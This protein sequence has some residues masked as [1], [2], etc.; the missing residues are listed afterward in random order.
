MNIFTKSIAFAFAGVFFAGSVSAQTF[1]LDKDTVKAY[2]SG[3]EQIHNDI[4]NT[5][6]DS[7]KLTWQVVYHNVNATMVAG[8]G[9]CDNQNCYQNVIGMPGTL[10]TTKYIHA[11]E[12]GSFDAQ[13]DAMIVPAGGPYYITIEFKNG[14]ET[15]YGTYE[16]YKWP[17]GI[18]T[19][20]KTDDI[21]LYPNPAKNDLNIFSGSL[22]VKTAVIT[23]TIGQVAAS[24]QLTG[25]RS[26]INIESLPS[27]TY[28]IKLLDAQNNVKAIRKIV[29]E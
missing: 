18:A 4:S 2:V 3:S 10:K 23:T 20:N 19:A 14:T 7:I 17:T 27:G 6:T 21:M 13:F 16:F 28:F 1:H 22:D 11:G 25:S 24:Y 26:N 9:I 12:K 29:H 15:K 5:H 8:I